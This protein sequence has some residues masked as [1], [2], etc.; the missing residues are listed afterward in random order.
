[1]NLCF[2]WFGPL[3]HSTFLQQNEQQA[4]PEVLLD[5]LPVGK[6]QYSAW[7]Q[8]IFEQECL[9]E[10]LHH[11]ASAVTQTTQRVANC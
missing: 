6:V 8:G 9:L 1:M 2:R 7:Q 3:Y 5:Q 4:Q 11:Y 10:R